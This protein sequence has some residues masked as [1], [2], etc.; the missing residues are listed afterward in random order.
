HWDVHVLPAREPYLRP[1]GGIR[2]D[3]TPL[4]D[5]RR[6]EDL[7]PV[8]DRRDRL[9]RIEEVTN[10][11]DHALIQPDVL[12]RA[13]ARDHQRVVILGPHIGERRVQPEVVAPLLAV[14]LV[15][16]EAV[17]G[18]PHRLPGLL[19]GTHCVNR[20]AAT[21]ER[22][23][24]HHDLVVLDEVADQHEDLLTHDAPPGMWKS[25]GA[26][27]TRRGGEPPGPASPTRVRGQASRRPRADARLADAAR[28]DRCASYAV[29]AGIT[30]TLARGAGQR[31]KPGAGHRARWLRRPAA[32]PAP[33]GQTR[34]R[35]PALS[36]GANSQEGL[37]PP[38]PSRRD[39]RRRAHRNV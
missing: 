6:R 23:E 14:G 28:R 1:D 2:R 35:R 27:R 9:V 36:R 37:D 32:R 7:R 34:P 15:A 24:R 25:G 10:G 5:V 39:A 12:G 38:R 26:G 4:D 30:S 13:A 8:A 33:R 21:L 19:P 3:A 22:L 29:P 11:P 18:R 16:L 31:E 20:V 17:D